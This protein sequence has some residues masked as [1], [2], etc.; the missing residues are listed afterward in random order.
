[1]T[2]IKMRRRAKRNEELTS[3]R[4]RAGVGHRQKAATR[5]TQFFVELICEI[6][7]RT[8]ASGARRISTL[9][10]ESRNDAMKN[11]AIIIRLVARL[12]RFHIGVFALASGESN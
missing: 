10:H 4:A 1:M 5:V 11:H 6:I 12:F 7:A 3:I 2:V 8:A 9:N